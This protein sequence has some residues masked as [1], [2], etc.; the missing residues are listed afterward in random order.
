MTVDDYIKQHGDPGVKF[1]HHICMKCSQMVQQDPFYLKEHLATHD[2]TLAAY[3]QLFEAQMNDHSEN[4]NLN[5][6]ESIGD[7][8][9]ASTLSSTSKSSPGV[10]GDFRKSVDNLSETSSSSNMQDDLKIKECTVNLTPIDNQPIE[11]SDEN[12]S[13]DGMN[14]FD[15]INIKT[16]P[17]IEIGY[18]GNN[19]FDMFQTIFN[20]PSLTMKP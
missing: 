20:F 13:E 18:F 5:E 4:G 8:D 14:M 7:A 11:A 19:E 3:T 9:I 10:P 15:V 6:K 16:E 1:Q 2:L 17:D 12:S